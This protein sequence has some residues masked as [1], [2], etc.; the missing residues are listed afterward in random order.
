MSEAFPSL[1]TQQKRARFGYH[2]FERVHSLQFLSAHKNEER[3]CFEVGLKS[4]VVEE[5]GHPL[6]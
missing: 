3:L 1:E 5:N 4:V 2:G 6:I